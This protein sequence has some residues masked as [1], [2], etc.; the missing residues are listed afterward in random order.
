MDAIL[1]PIYS[2]LTPIYSMFTPIDAILT[3]IY[4]IL[5][6]IDALSMPSNA[7]VLSFSVAA[8]CAPGESVEVAA[9]LNELL[10]G[11]RITPIWGEM[12][13]NMPFFL[14]FKASRC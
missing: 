11:V 13:A 5:T 12:T 10:D 14:D 3:P 4:S 6:P 8:G 7:L 1:T 9:A 2:I